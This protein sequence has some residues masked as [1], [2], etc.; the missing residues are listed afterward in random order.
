MSFEDL[1]WRRRRFV[2]N[3]VGIS[4][5]NATDAARR[6]G[7]SWPDRQGPRLLRSV[8]V[9]QAISNKVKHLAITPENVLERLQDHACADLSDF[10]RVG[11]DGTFRIDLRKAMLQGKLHVVKRIKQDKDGNVFLELHDA[12]IALVKLGSHFGIFDRGL[13][14]VSNYA[15][16]S[17]LARD[18]PGAGP[19][20]AGG[21]ELGS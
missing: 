21:G 3:Y 1:S 6:A 7:Y 19:H 16:E 10:I 14:G 11:R 15:V 17:V 12:Q 9:R 4:N 5:G 20:Q 13:T 18:L 8:V 2:E